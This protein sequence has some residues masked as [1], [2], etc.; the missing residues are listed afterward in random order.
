[1]FSVLLISG[2]GELE[3][4]LL[5]QN[6]NREIQYLNG[7]EQKKRNREQYI[8]A[9][10]YAISLLAFMSLTNQV[11]GPYRKIRTEFLPF[12]LWPKRDTQ[13]PLI[14]GEKSRIRTWRRMA[15]HH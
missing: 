9:R 1:M 2:Q 7:I 3:T 10:R 11:R 5:Y 4:G 8:G 6:R 13:G 15:G 12:D 14:V